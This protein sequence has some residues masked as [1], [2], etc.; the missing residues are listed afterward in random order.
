MLSYYFATILMAVIATNLLII[1][2]TLCFCSS[3]LM[4]NAGYKLLALFILF[5]VLR[6]V[7]PIEL[8]FTVSLYWPD[9]ISQGIWQLY[10]PLFEIAGR[11]VSI[12]NAFQNIWILGICIHLMLYAFSYLRSKHSITLHAKTVTK[13]EPY[14]GIINRICGEQN[15]PNKFI[16]AELPGI[17]APVLYGIFRPRIFIPEGMELSDQ[18]WY[19]VLRHEA[20]HH[21][22][23]D[24]LM[25]NIIRLI[26]IVYWWNPFCA[27]L[28]KQTDIILEMRI[29]DALTLRNTEIT[30]A[31]IRCLINV[32]ESIVSTK[33]I[34]K[35][36]TM[37]L[38][39]KG[40]TDMGKRLKMLVSNQQKRNVPLNIL[41]F[42]LA[43]TIYILSYIFIIEAFHQPEEVDSNPAPTYDE[44]VKGP[45]ETVYA[46]PNSIGTYDIYYGGIY[47][48]T[49]SSLD[50]YPSASV[51]TME[52]L[53]DLMGDSSE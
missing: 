32:S 25:K 29:D 28:N 43:L 12:V 21:F 44:M 49:V 50:Y 45:A 8:P 36:F 2:L 30:G 3:K 10:D 5:A 4:I 52:E 41:L 7:L 19:Y 51:C 20:S 23:H 22:H 53:T 35:T 48:E 46:V 27:A 42:T 17:K 15:R 18:D 37:S 13:A 16:L 33:L 31:Y 6:F 9:S 38:L 11:P 47:M 14:C 1:L 26:T 34:P 40:T 24:I 39:H